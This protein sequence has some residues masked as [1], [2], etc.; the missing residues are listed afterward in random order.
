MYASI[1]FIHN[2]KSGKTS[3]A[4]S[5]IC[6]KPEIVVN[7]NEIINETNEKLAIG[8]KILTNQLLT[9]GGSQIII[10]RI[11]A[12]KQP[13]ATSES[14]YL[15]KLKIYIVDE[16]QV[17]DEKKL[18]NITE[19]ILDVSVNYTNS[20]PKDYN[21]AIILKGEDPGTT[22]CP[23]PLMILNGELSSNYPL[24]INFPQVSNTT[25]NY[26]R[27]VFPKG[28]INY[29]KI[30]A[31]RLIHFLF[32]RLGYNNKHLHQKFN[33]YINIQSAFEEG[34]AS[35]I[36]CLDLDNM[37]LCDWENMHFLAV[38]Q[39]LKLQPLANMICKK[40][41][42]RD[43]VGIGINDFYEI[44]NDD[45]Q[46]IENGEFK[47][48]SRIEKKI[49]YVIE[50]KKDGLI[51]NETPYKSKNTIGLIDEDWSKTNFEIRDTLSN[52]FV[53]TN[54]FSNRTKI[55]NGDKVLIKISLETKKEKE[56]HNYI[57]RPA[58]FEVEKVLKKGVKII[59]RS[60]V[61][62]KFKHFKQKVILKIG[63][64][65]DSKLVKRIAKNVKK[66]TKWQ[67]II[68][69]SSYEDLKKTYEILKG[70]NENWKTKPQIRGKMV[71]EMRR[72]IYGLAKVNDVED[73][74]TIIVYMFPETFLFLDDVIG[75]A[76]SGLSIDRI[77]AV[78]AVY[79]GFNPS[80]H[81]CRDCMNKPINLYTEEMTALFIIHEVLH[82]AAGLDDHKVCAF[83]SYS[84]DKMENFR[85]YYC[86]KCIRTGN[87]KVH[88]NC[89]MSRG[90]LYC[91]CARM[92]NLSLSQILCED[93]KKKLL[94]PEQFVVRQ[95]ARMNRIIYRSFLDGVP[96]FAKS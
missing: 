62:Q 39:N 53:P 78:V 27:K 9:N 38:Q 44:I 94:P 18:N 42:I 3:L 6:S 7:S 60:K 51:L 13:V 58:A 89:L 28:E 2:I 25:L 86:E 54:L 21:L 95:A 92:E 40:C 87:D 29:T 88:K 15:K 59:G 91:I 31:F 61:L 70:I 74:F 43:V 57:T 80:Y 77:F 64:E 82:I 33:Q 83:C 11:L 56:K 50:S 52:I 90:C 75:T 63:P 30:F 10:E 4:Q 81:F 85:R 34:D 12:R 72:T 65:I 37:Y 84:S 36:P 66:I 46:I 73:K 68:D 5:A 67:V 76:A 35:K 32:H 71:S 23:F 20:I 8:D 49:Y 22:D 24:D 26:L 45:K 17:L 69:K 55:K 41:K 47:Q 14:Q 96:D 16:K 1:H 93:C 48:S 79:S 19:K